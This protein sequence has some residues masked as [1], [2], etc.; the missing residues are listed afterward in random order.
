MHRERICK[1]RSVICENNTCDVICNV[2]SCTYWLVSTKI[3]W[4]RRQVQHMRRRSNG[5]NPEQSW[6]RAHRSRHSQIFRGWI[7]T[8]AI[9]VGGRCVAVSFKVRIK[10][11]AC[12]CQRLIV[13]AYAWKLKK[14]AR[15]AQTT[16]DERQSQG[17]TEGKR[18][19]KGLNTTH[20][21]MQDRIKTA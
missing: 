18:V 14:S 19:D 13:R 12:A 15:T 3:R 1:R 16:R 10:V 17:V 7:L 6:D 4:R 9:S 21:I 8:K 5:C 11:W 2:P 20:G